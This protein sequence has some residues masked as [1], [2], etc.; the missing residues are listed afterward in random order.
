MQSTRQ[1]V[2]FMN[3]RAGRGAGSRLVQELARLLND[4][5]FSVTQ[6]DKIEGLVQHMAREPRVDA[7][8]AAGGD[9]TVETVVNATAAHVP[10]AVFPLGTENLLAKYLGIQADPRRLVE[11]ISLGRT[12]QFDAG[13]ANGKLFLIMLSC[14]FDAEVVRR[15]HD[16]RRGNITHLAYAKPI[17]DSIWNYDYPNLRVCWNNDDEWQEVD[18]HWA[19]LFNAPSYAGGLQVVSEADP[20]DGQ[21]EIATFTGGSFW[22]GLW[23]FGTV[24]LG[25]H[26]QLPG[27]QLN[28][29]NRIRIDSQQQDVPY[30]IDGDPGGFLPV[31]VEVLPRHLT[32]IVDP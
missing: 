31:E 13:R 9:G 3:P 28:R 10:I 26:R 23:H 8:I 1:I 4:Y 22:H 18:C 24:V 12:I 6:I 20:S 19:F 16:E 25:Q 14:G 17:V 30:Q 11:M 27:F 15:L 21:F 32:L 29:S 2:L 5:G 7:V